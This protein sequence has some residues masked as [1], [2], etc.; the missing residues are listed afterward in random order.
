MGINTQKVVV[1]G[2]AAGIVMNVVGF[3]THGV[4]LGARMNAEMDAVVPGLS[5]RMVNATTMTV[6]VVTQLAIGLVLVW[7]YAAIRP[8]FGPG[9][10]TA[11]R[12]AIVIWV[13]GLFF[14]SG[15]YLTG[16]TTASTYLLASIAALVNLL[17]GA[18]VGGMLYKEEGAGAPA[19]ASA[20]T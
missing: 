18:Y 14:Y 1:G 10:A 19:M 11:A 8:R 20:R 4:M 6:N 9:F 7:L 17:A 15:W 5:T 13:C 16:M 2:I 12:A 3:L